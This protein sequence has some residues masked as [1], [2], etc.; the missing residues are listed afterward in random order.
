MKTEVYFSYQCIV[1][2]SEFQPDRF[3]SACPH[4]KGLLMVERDEKR[5]DYY[6]GQGREA[7]N[8]FDAIRYGNNRGVYPNG[9]GVFMWLPH[10]LPGFPVEAVVSLR[11]GHTDLWEMPDWFKG[12]V[13][14]ER[15]F[16]KMEGQ[17]PSASF[18]DR[19]MCVAVSDAL[20]LQREAGSGKRWTIMCSSTGDTSASAGTY[21]AYAR[22]RLECV[23]VLPFGGTSTGQV[24][25]TRAAGAT[26]AFVQDPRGFDAGMEVVEQYC[27]LHPEVVL[28]NSKNPM[29][30]V[31]QESIALEICQDLKWRAPDWISIPCGNGGNLTAFLVSLSRMKQRGLIDRLPGIIVAQAEVANT[32]VRWGRSGFQKYEPGVRQVSVASAMNIQDPVSFGRIRKLHHP[33]DVRFYDVPEQRIKET[34]GLWM[35]TGVSICPQT[36]VALDAVMQARQEGVVNRG[37][38]VVVIGTASGLKFPTDEGLQYREFTIGASVEDLAAQL[39]ALQVR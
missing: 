13:G 21:A 38:T 16:I 28:V 15:L 39:A 26:N 3:Y 12:S 10:L 32:L 8:F 18:K 35:S 19:G 17:L 20:R 33:F 25:Q 31:G 7:Q 2:G 36:A 30:I 34:R 27:E 29:R 23:V 1:C 22:D 24:F 4:C 6:V 5:I 37:D 9:S 14:M 11:E